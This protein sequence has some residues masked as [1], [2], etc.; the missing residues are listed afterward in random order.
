LFCYGRQKNKTLRQNSKLCQGM[1]KVRDI[2]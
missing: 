1:V 2:T